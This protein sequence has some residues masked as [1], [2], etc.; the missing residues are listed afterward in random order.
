LKAKS[1]SDSDLEQYRRA[2][3]LAPA[4]AQAHANL[5]VALQRLGQLELGVAS[6]RRALELD[7]RMTA[8]HEIMAPALHALGQD[9]AATD[10]YR[11]LLAVQPDNPTLHHG[12]GEA[13]R[14]LGQ[15]DAAADSYQRA[16]ALRPDDVASH[17]GLG[18]AQQGM[19]QF[20]AAAT[21]FGR[22]L[23][24][25]PGHIDARLNLAHTFIHTGQFA[26][27]AAG[28]EDVLRQQPENYEALMNLATC[29][30]GMGKFEAALASSQR[31]L[32]ARPGDLA[33]RR[34]LAA[35]LHRLGKH[36]DALALRQGLLEAEP[37]N[38][39]FHF[40]VGQSLHALG[41]P[42]P[43]LASL[44][45]ALELLP[46]DATIHSFMAY[47]AIEFGERDES[48]ASYR[49]AMELAPSAGAYSNV[50]FLLSHCT[51]DPA[52]LFA[53][54]LRFGEQF[55]TPWLA[56]RIPHSNQL[57]PERRLNVGFVSADFY[58]HAAS[59]FI[60]P[61][62]EL[63]AHSTELSLHA[64]YNGFVDDHV[65]GRLRGH[66][67]HWHPIAALDDDAV[68]RQIRADGIDILIDLSGHSGGNRLTLFARKPAP[69]QASWIG[70]AGTTGLQA[71]DYYVTD[72]FHLPEGRY[73]DQFTEKI[74][75][76]PLGAAFMPEPSAP[77]VSPLPALSNGYLT[78]GTFNRANKLSRDVIALWAN[79]LRA[80]PTAR[81]VLG[82]LHA[83]ADTL[84]LDW[85]LHEGI[86]RERL[87]VQPR[88]NISEYLEAHHQ[89]DICLAPFPYTGATTVCHALWMGVP[90]LTVTGPTNPSHGA[91]CYLAH[92][93]LGA[94]AADGNANF[95]KLG[96]FLSENLEELAGLRATMRERFTASVAGQPVVAAAGLERALRLMWQR[97]C[98]GLPPEA[99][100]VRLADLM[101]PDPEPEA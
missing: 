100:R 17:L 98:A 31:A 91:V 77:P 70:Y 61:I 88:G 58:N 89:V 12:L 66:F 14:G 10:S 24:L 20:D 27:A 97:W 65:T 43:A 18:A 74:V 72:G 16:L 86:D 25:E 67:S 34:S 69:V 79:L 8:L 64:Y 21:T 39:L 47:V 6:Q 93:G 1:K 85:L 53:E 32:E 90:T 50:L 80:V 35:S 101:T 30:D 22:V 71:M 26:A 82:G 81:L 59:T 73:D 45:R 29:L 92:L 96:V 23:A 57:D 3:R 33:A 55:E 49:R 41:L 56:R 76:I 62:F 28:Y 38:G 9:E 63:L 4:S 83:G 99:I 87:I 11:R 44:H 48:L 75:R 15:Y 46:D 42:G 84:V 51:S 52:E 19:G 54:H 5:G 95:I 37:D 94:F 68:E 2:V 78:F 13:L 60:E 40:G 7:P 36:A